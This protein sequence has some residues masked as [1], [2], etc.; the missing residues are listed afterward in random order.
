LGANSLVKWP[1]ASAGLGALLLFIQCS[2]A[3]CDKRGMMKQR[4]FGYLLVVL[5]SAVAPQAF[6]ANEGTAVGV[7]PDA[8][9][10][11]NSTDR[12]L[13]VGSDVSVGELIVTG[14]AGQV[15]IVFDDDTRL[16]VGPRS[17][18]LIETYLMANANTAQ[19]LTINA[20][21]GSF[22][23]ITGNSPK[24]AYSIKTPTASIAVRGTEVDIIS[25]PRSTKVMLYEGA[26]QICSTGGT[27][28]EL[29]RMCEVGVTTRTEADLFLRNNPGRAPLSLEFRYAQFQSG[30]LAPFRVNSPA[31]CV[32]APTPEANTGSSGSMTVP[33]PPPPRPPVVRN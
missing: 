14:S 26:L 5:L 16:V 25:Q 18:L 12:I 15:Q 28:E 11:I 23:F 21:G 3:Y 13:Q 9:A 30:L 17:K 22:R 19:Q 2:V 4:V 33:T 1:F 31:R 27:C 8:S 29:T 32:E 24:P 7:N 6:A 10:Q 20:L